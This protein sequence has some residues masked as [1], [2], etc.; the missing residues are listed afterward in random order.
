MDEDDT[1]GLKM[2][3]DMN[4]VPEGLPPP[5][6]MH[7]MICFGT[8]QEFDEAV[9]HLVEPEQYDDWKHTLKEAEGDE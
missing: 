3:M 2:E 9:G 7:R 5:L 1:V 4:K 6:E 8:P